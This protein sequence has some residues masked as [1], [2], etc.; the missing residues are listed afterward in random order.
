MLLFF[1]TPVLIRHLCQL[2]T[3]VFLHWCLMRVVLFQLDLLIPS[4]VIKLSLK[5]RQTDIR[6]PIHIICLFDTFHFTAFVKSELFFFQFL[7]L[8]QSN[9]VISFY[10]SLEI[11][12]APLD[13]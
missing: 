4:I 3:V 12:E 2:K 8:F 13:I 5:D 9:P 6:P 1:S 10:I 7:F 11:F